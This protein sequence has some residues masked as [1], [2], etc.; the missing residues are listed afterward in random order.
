M[1]FFSA[2]WRITFG[3][4]CLLTSLLVIARLIGI[5]PSVEQKVVSGRARLCETLAVN[6]SALVSLNEIERL[7]KV[8]EVIVKRNPELRSAAIH[9]ASDGQYLVDVGDHQRWWGTAHEEHSSPT[10]VHVPIHAGNRKW[11]T[12]ELIFYPLGGEGILSIFQLPSIRLVSFIGAASF[13]CFW[14]YLGRTLR[15][16]DPSKAVPKRVRSALDT[17]TEGLL[18]LDRQGRIVLANDAFSR[19]LGKSPESLMGQLA[20]ELP[21][22]GIDKRKDRQ[23]FPWFRAMS[24][25]LPSASDT[26]SLRDGDGSQRMLVANAAPVSGQSGQHTGVLISF[27]D[28]TEL[29]ASRLALSKAKDVADSANRAKSDFL[30]RM[31]HEIRTPMNAILGFTDVLRRG[32]DRSVSDRQRYLDTIHASG[33]HLLALIN[34]IL[35]LSKI[36]SGRM[37]LEQQPCSPFDLV[38]HV[39][40]VFQMKADEKKIGLHLECRGALPETILTD[41]VRF[42]QTVMNLVSNSIKFTE[43]GSVTVTLEL[44]DHETSE[45]KLKVDVIDTGVGISQESIGKIFDPFSQADSSITRRFGGTGLGLAICRQ[46]AEAMGGSVEVKSELG[47]GSTFSVTFATGSLEGVAWVEADELTARRDQ[48]GQVADDRQLPPSRVLVVDDGE[49]NR[50]LIQLFLAQ[51]GCEVD[52]AENGEVAIQRIATTVYDAVL[53]DMQMPVMDGYTATKKLREIGCNLPIIAL[54]AHAMQGDEAK[55]RD[56]GCTGFMTKPVDIDRLYQTLAEVLSST[57]VPGPRTGSSTLAVKTL[58]TTTIDDSD[59]TGE[60]SAE[61]EIVHAVETLRAE[62]AAAVAVNVEASASDIEAPL[63]CRLPMDDYRFRPIIERFHDRAI[64]RAETMQVALANRDFDKL[65]DLAHWLK[66][67]GGTA[68]FDDFTAPAQQLE[69]AAEAK[70]LALAEDCLATIVKLVKRLKIPTNV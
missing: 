21:W 35:D 41:K 29:E 59:E 53:M 42:R 70:D 26:M 28:V 17:L 58:A 63:T 24:E 43:Q 69:A 37:D 60:P 44:V 3:L 51:F 54:T 32:F 19:W 33:E 12:V 1:R 8:L 64:D 22:I 13:V 57:V 9:R 27:E 68:G 46:L 25:N 7:E 4:V 5:I 55:C 36:E 14:F 18:V 16:L 56:A 40:S 15:Q 66:G 50:E 48:R 52:K 67:T 47:K 31:S 23:A 34:D 30:A 39:V 6:C 2:R 38:A 65:R 61:A 10:H 49:A 62:A 20:D 45:P 11:G